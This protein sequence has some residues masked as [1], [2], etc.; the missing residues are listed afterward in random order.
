MAHLPFTAALGPDSNM[1]FGRDER[2]SNRSSY[3]LLCR[4]RCLPVDI[5]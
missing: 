1:N 2:Y 3:G 5:D 4:G